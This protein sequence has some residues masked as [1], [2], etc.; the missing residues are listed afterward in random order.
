MYRMVHS[1]YGWC[2]DWVT[3]TALVRRYAKQRAAA[4]AST[5]VRIDEDDDDDDDDSSESSVLDQREVELHFW[6]KSPRLSK[7]HLRAGGGGSAPNI[8]ISET[9]SR[10][11]SECDESPGRPPCEGCEVHSVAI[12]P[13]LA[14]CDR[15]FQTPFSTNSSPV[16]SFDKLLG[17]LLVTAQYFAP[18]QRVGIYHSYLLF[19]ISER[20]RVLAGDHRQ[21]GI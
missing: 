11:A 7:D 3:A 13:F 8:V 5:A 2:F 4:P 20:A 19:A 1:C 14:N 12:D 17:K 6:K 18:K 10:S 15:P 21:R 9:A 16:P